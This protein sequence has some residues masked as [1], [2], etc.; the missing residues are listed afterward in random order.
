[1]EI[2]KAAKKC[3]DSIYTEIIL[4]GEFQYEEA[5]YFIHRACEEYNIEILD[6]VQRLKKA[7]MNQR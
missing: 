3:A 1:M 2:S 6:E 7:L 4:K 5:L